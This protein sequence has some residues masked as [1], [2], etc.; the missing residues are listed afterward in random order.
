V[1]RERAV[2]MGKLTEDLMLLVRA[3]EGRRAYE[4]AE[5]GLRELV[6]ASAVRLRQAAA[7][8]GVTLDLSGTGGFV[9]WADARLA[10]R[11]FD[12]LLQNAVRYNREGGRVEASA[13]LVPGAGSAS[14]DVVSIRISD[15]GHGI[16]VSE[17]ER[18]FDRFYRTDP[19]RSRRT[20][21]MGLGLAICR[22]ALALLGGSVRVLESSDSGTTFEVRLPGHS[23]KTG[24]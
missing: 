6:D 2:E 8:R 5:V 23:S 22:E 18:V 19:S 1:L 15:T 21:G 13:S 16:P 7:E 10:S 17:R 14:P 3:Q 12:N 24:A 20:G 9:V 4:V 11:V